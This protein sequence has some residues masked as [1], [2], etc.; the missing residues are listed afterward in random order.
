[1]T[2]TET[3]DEHGA[4]EP[5]EGPDADAS[6][7]PR[8]VEA[9]TE[10]RAA[11]QPEAVAV[12]GLSDA[13]RKRLRRGWFLGATP[14][15]ALYTWVLTAGRADLFQRRE[16]YD[17]FFDAQGRAFFDGHLDVPPEVA[18]WEGFLV[19]G[20]TYIYFGP[21]PTL[22]RIP[23]L[24]LTSEYDGRLTAVSMLAAM[25]VLTIFAFRL[26]CVLRMTLRGAV[27]VGTR[28]VWASA[29]L[30]V[31]ALAGPVF[32]LASAALVFH[33]ATMWGVAL[34]V[35]SLDAI[36]RWQRDP[37]PERLA[38][39]A[40]AV[41]LALLSRQAVGLGALIALG[42]AGALWLLQRYRQ[43][44]RDSPDRPLGE[45]VRALVRPAA[46][47][48][49]ATVLAAAPA[50]GIHY[51]KFQMLFGVPIDKQAISQD[52]VARGDQR[53]EVLETNPNFQGFEYVPTTA[54]QYFRP[55]AVAPRGDFP[56]IDFP[57]EGPDQVN[58]DVAFDTLDW[59]SS[60]PT[61]APALTALSLIGLAW[62]IRTRRERAAVFGGERA[63]TTS[64]SLAPVASGAAAGAAGILAFAYV[65]NRYLSDIYPL[66]LVGSLVGFHALAASAPSWRLWVRR[67][68]GAGLC[69]LLA[70]GVV[71]NFTLTLQYQRERGHFVPRE[72][73]AQWVHWRIQL[74]GEQTVL[75]MGGEELLPQPPV[76][77]GALLVAGD[78]DRLFAGVRHQ[79]LLIEDAEDDPATPICSE[80]TESDAAETRSHRVLRGAGTR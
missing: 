60:I 36:A 45:A 67:L 59:S 57:R 32:F 4:A 15:I 56:W 26:C 18:S 80:A 69:A 64:P 48:G 5:D 39:A 16:R 9:P 54:W 7:K 79:W 28:E 1:M 17:D 37:T 53:A 22:I 43:S 78:C 52:L 55:D 14:V 74:P 76:A 29:P 12:D 58:P 66:F 3:P 47:I 10:A 65:A 6:T 49:L 2:E 33:E 50:V 51:A 20:K 38:I 19:D 73:L 46:G 31:A 30:A 71:I 11:E 63:G 23:I 25:I 27:P 77:D 21:F 24:L 34:T 61:T 13:D 40:L 70:L 41:A 68:T 62:A 72:W 8:A 44:R 35:A 75:Y 42:L